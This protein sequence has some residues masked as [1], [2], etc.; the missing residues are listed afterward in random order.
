MGNQCGGVNGQDPSA[1]SISFVFVM[2]GLV[3]A[4]HAFL[5]SL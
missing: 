3:P 4:I 1:F 2:A 5:V